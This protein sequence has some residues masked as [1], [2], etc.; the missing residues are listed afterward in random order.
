[1]SPG[2]L[3]TVVVSVLSG[4]SDGEADS[5]RVPRANA[6]D[7]AE[8]TV[9][10]ARETS[11]TPTGDNTLS[12]VTLGGAQYVDTLILHSMESMA[13]ESSGLASACLTVLVTQSWSQVDC[14]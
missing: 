4:T 1:M 12:S 9:G 10:L 3:G 5:G 7:L 2:H 14:R 11:H 8:P 13:R 6:R